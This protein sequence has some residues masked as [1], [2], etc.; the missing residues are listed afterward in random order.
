VN[1]IKHLNK[2]VTA[3]NGTTADYLAMLAFINGNDMTVAE[4]YEMA[5]SLID[6][7]N[8]ADYMLAEM[9]IH[10]G[11]WPDNNVRAWKSPE[12]PWKFMIYD[13]D[14]G[15]Q[16]D[17]NVSGFSESTNM[18]KW[19]KQGGKNG[20]NSDNLCFAKL[21]NNLIKNDNFKRLFVNHASVMLGSYLNGANVTA[22]AKFLAGML[23]ASDVSRDMAVEAY[24]DRRGQY[25]H[26]FDP[27]GEKLGPW[28]NERDDVFKSEIQSEFGLSGMGT[29]KIASNGK[30]VVLM[31]GMNL[32]GSTSSSTNY[33][34][35][36][37]TG[38]MMELT[39][40][41]VEGAVFAGWSDGVTEATRF[42][43]VVDGLTLTA[44]FK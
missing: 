2:T 16:W 23:D 24:M 35:K 40:V 31:E 42:V 13:L 5:K 33:S 43:A 39:A 18:F 44:N 36:F 4:N 25:S 15:F 38:G 6:I 8:F 3:S 41:P 11:D 32:P 21:Y 37:F 29:V 30:G 20:C 34:G 12:T 17:W 26:S 14:H 19:V 7:G 28:A 22:K 1:F 27:Y 10:N 9:Y